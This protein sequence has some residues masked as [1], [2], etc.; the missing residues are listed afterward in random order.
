MRVNNRRYN[1]RINRLG[2]ID[3]IASGM[4][5]GS[6]DEGETSSSAQGGQAQT[7]TATTVSPTFQQAFTPQISP[8]IQVSTGSGSQSAATSQ[9]IR[10]GQSAKGGS[11]SREDDGLMTS[12]PFVDNFAGESF[13]NFTPENDGV[14]QSQ[15]NLGALV[16][17]FIGGAVILT[18]V[19]LF[20]QP[21][22]RAI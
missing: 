11:G 5:G 8:V 13:D 12:P 15:N 16:P 6:G 21:E 3:E 2:F 4:V 19:Y 7:D 1:R 9:R 18:S 17:W 20:T 14:F 10:G 22:K